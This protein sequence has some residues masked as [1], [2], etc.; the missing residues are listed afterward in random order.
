MKCRPQGRARVIVDKKGDDSDDDDQF[1]TK[2]DETALHSQVS[3]HR[4]DEEEE[5][6]ATRDEH[7]QLVRKLLGSKKDFD[8]TNQQPKKVVIEVGHAFYIILIYVWIIERIRLGV[9]DFFDT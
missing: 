5:G 2:E 6:E 4:A 1:V 8:A 3:Q 9:D 7:G